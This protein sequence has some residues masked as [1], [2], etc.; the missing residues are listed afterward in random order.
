MFGFIRRCCVV[1]GSVRRSK[2]QMMYKL[3]IW[4][5]IPS[6]HQSAFFKALDG[7]NDIDLQVRYFEE[8]S[9]SRAAEGWGC[10]YNLASYEGCVAGKREPEA[11]LQT[12]PDWKERVHLISAN[13]SQE[14]IDLFCD[15]KV[16]WCHWSEM[17]GMRLA[18]LLGYR[19]SLFRILNPLMLLCKRAQGRCIRKHALGSF[20]QGLLAR[21]AFSV[22]G[23]PN[24]KIVD[25]YYVPAA[26]DPM[27]A[28][29]QIVKFADGRKVFLS[30]GALCERKGI[31]ILLK[32]FARLKAKDWCLVLCGLDK[33][34]GRYQALSEKLDIKD[35]ILFLGV[36]P[37]DRIAE[38]Y[39]AA[40]VFILPSR[41]DGWG[42]VLNEAASLGM[43]LIATDMCGAAWHV[44][45]DGKNGF[46]V[47]V[48]SVCDL[49]E[50]MMAYI[51]QPQL[52][53]EH[54]GYS[55]ELFLREFSPD[56]N[57]ERLVTAISHWTAR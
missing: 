34:E 56:R 5:N 20:G 33:F 26:L 9:Q 51:A 37:S 40:D 36:Y 48:G 14:L 44:I 19:M 10:I 38:V 31:D 50:K 11:M 45:E 16:N 39:T 23:V 54:G 8:V 41:F 15:E 24:G 29:E 4:M 35:C 47:K 13:F 55:S 43:P 27:M 52:I 32:A 28:C 21:K 3:C 12:L 7:R 25:L 30:V 17:P 2:S 1:S 46:R 18:E 42:A 57:A 22:M 53:Q 6:H 49:A